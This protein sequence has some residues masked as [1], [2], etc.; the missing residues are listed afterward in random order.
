ML[1][2]AYVLNFIK[3]MTSPKVKKVWMRPEVSNRAFI[4]DFLKFFW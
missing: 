1:P 2:D 4:I 3:L